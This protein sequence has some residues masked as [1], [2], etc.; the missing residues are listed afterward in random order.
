MKDLQ[1]RALEFRAIREEAREV[2][3]VASTETPDAHDSI[4][5]ANWDTARYESNPVVLWAHESREL[6][7]GV[8]T[9]VRVVKKELL[10][11]VRFVGADVNPKAEQVWQG[12]KQGVIRG[13]S[14]GFYPRSVR[15]EKQ[16]D[17]ELL[18]LDD[19]EL[20][21]LS[22]T[23]I[24]S[25]P[26]TLAKLRSRALAD[27]STKNVATDSPSQETPAVERGEAQETPMSTENETAALKTKMAERD[28]ENRI[29]EKTIADLR[30]ERDVLA[31]QTKTLATERDAL[32]ARAEKAEGE[33]VERE[34]DA[35]VGVK[36]TP[37]EKPSFIKLARANR[38]L[39]SEM[40]AQRGDLGM[41]DG[42]S[43]LPAEGDPLQKRDIVGSD[44][45]SLFNDFSKSLS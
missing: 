2:D 34:V 10:A 30:A 25:N 3:F 19:N 28:A 4:V 20:L 17:R 29:A 12:V 43:A 5:K 24:P 9:K 26:E 8:A 40:V 37:A 13:M 45:D 18:V 33:L 21:E 38:E 35:L 16:N 23:P 7:I 15:V 41:R 14:V 22:I 31:A 27:A 36:I 32:K 42:K 6:P 1:S 44:V 39:F 11:T